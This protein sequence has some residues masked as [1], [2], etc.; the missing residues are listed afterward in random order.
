MLDCTIHGRSWWLSNCHSKFQNIFLCCVRNHQA[1]PRNVGWKSLLYRTFF[2]LVTSGGFFFFN[3][4]CEI[5]NNITVVSVFV[6]GNWL[7]RPSK[8]EK[9]LT[10]GNFKSHACPFTFAVESL[11]NTI[12]MKIAEILKWD[13]G[14]SSE[15]SIDHM[16][17]AQP[18]FHTALTACR[19]TLCSGIKRLG[20]NYWRISSKVLMWRWQAC[21]IWGEM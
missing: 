9:F 20:G 3:T 4:S 17:T 21:I 7:G 11:W 15:S 14:G 2:F 8:S 18:I 10:F 5:G 6:L 19:S 16:A 13:R 12:L 1:W